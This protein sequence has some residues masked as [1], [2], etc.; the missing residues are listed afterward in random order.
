MMNEQL[1][2]KIK[3]LSFLATVMV[4]YRHSL[5]YLAF[6]NSWSGEGVNGFIQDGCMVLTQVA[7]PYFFLVSGFFF[8]KKDYYDIQEYRSML[9]KKCKTLFIPFVIWNVVGLL[10]LIVTGQYVQAASAGEFFLAL[11]D[12]RY[13]G[14]LWYVRDLMTLMLIVPFYQCIYRWNNW[15]VYAI[16]FA[17]LYGYW[18]PIDCGWISSEGILFFFL[19]GILQKHSAYLCKRLSGHWICLMF[20]A[21]VVLCFTTP[22]F[23]YLHKLC[24]LLGVIT[25]WLMTDHIP[26][27]HS[28]GIIKLTTY[29]FLIYVL[30]F[31]PIKVMKVILGKY[32]FG[33]EWVSLAAYLIL[34]IIT[35]V[36]VVVIGC[37]MRRYMPKLYNLSTGNR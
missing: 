1:S 5:N 2:A 36:I 17:A 15:V 10:C 31:Y 27:I 22:F 14:P 21:W 11:M 33:N 6:F 34:P 19:A 28:K 20:V 13:Y 18:M 7:V 37:I 26:F 25:F 16:V 24:T 35:C 30:H 9:A 8:F 12:S 3:I 29:S 4:V 32:F 23:Q